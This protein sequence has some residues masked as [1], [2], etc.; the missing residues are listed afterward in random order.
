M[1]LSFKSKLQVFE[2][3][4]LLNDVIDIILD[5]VDY[6]LVVKIDEIEACLEHIKSEVVNNYG[7]QRKVIRKDYQVFR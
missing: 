1:K 3:Q 5:D 7:E 6:T 2:A 4:K